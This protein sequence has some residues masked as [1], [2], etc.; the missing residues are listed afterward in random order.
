LAW[1]YIQSGSIWPPMLAHALNNAVAL[2]IAVAN[3]G[4]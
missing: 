2:S 1:V 4:G 3:A